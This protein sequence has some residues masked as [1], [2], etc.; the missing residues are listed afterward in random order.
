MKD[1]NAEMSP[2][3]SVI[4]PLY[5]SSRFMEEG[6]RSVLTQSFADL[7]LILVDD[8]SS[9]DTLARARQL[10]ANDARIVVIA[11]NENVGGGGSRNAGIEAARG[12]YIAFLDADDLWLP[13]KLTVQISSMGERG[14]A[15][16]Y[17]DFRVQSAD[18]RRS[19][20]SPTPDR[21]SYGDLLKATVIGCSTVV[22]DRDVLGSRFFPMIRKRQDFGLWLS[23][24]RDVDFAY[25]CG[26]ALT[27]YRV[28][29]GSVSSNKLNAAAYTWRVYREL[30][31][32]PLLPS[33]YYFACYATAAVRKR[34]R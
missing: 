20:V 1:V 14:A 3:V 29:P 30:E 27:H 8:F 7:E 4:M 23:I 12:R 25:R 15:F 19:R 22:Y 31:E 24:L 13:E 16:S 26:P 10:A 17:T 2:Q 21:V 5:N 32:L 6:V 11:L 18:G 28:R 33:M 34:M 9:D